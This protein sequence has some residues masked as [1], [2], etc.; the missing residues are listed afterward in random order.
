MLE[1]RFRYPIIL[2]TSI[3]FF[4]VFEFVQVTDLIRFQI[5]DAGLFVLTLF[6]VL[7]VWEGNRFIIRM[8]DRFVESDYTDV[9]T[10]WR[11]FFATFPL[12]T[13]YSVGFVVVLP[14]LGC[15]WF[16]HMPF[17]LL[18]PS[19]KLFSVFAFLLMNLMHTGNAVYYYMAKWK[20]SMVEAERFKKMS[21]E[22]QFEALRTQV[23]PHFL[24][25]SLN[26][27]ATLMQSNTEVASEFVHRLSSVY[28]YMISH[29]DDE[30]VDLQEE[31]EFANSY[32]FLLKTRFADSISINI[33]VPEQYSCCSM[34]PPV[35]LQMLIENAIKHNVVANKKPLKIEIFIEDGEFLVVRNNLQRKMYTQPSTRIGLNN[36]ERRYQFLSSRE[37]LVS[38]S[39]DYFT[40]KLPLLF[41][42]YKL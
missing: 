7:A 11:R 25:N 36:I 14:G 38:D 41:S 8:V 20:D 4:G 13:I 39:G 23:N 27:L 18:E 40:V 29:Q 21:V 17:D 24:F 42:E 31:I 9:K 35:T 5:S 15:M 37:I 2:I 1:F 16:N 12:A 33:N 19:L 6:I 3:F 22:S 34:I 26:T 28:R 10:M 32:L 30:L